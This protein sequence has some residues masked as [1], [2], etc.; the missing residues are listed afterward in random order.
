MQSHT[1]ESTTLRTVTYDEP[2][3]QLHLEFRDG[4]TYIYFDVPGCVYRALVG[5]PSKG[6]S[7][8]IRVRNHFPSERLAATDHPA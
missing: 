2:S 1:I 7:F 6:Q 5:A 3:Q 4:A 8:N